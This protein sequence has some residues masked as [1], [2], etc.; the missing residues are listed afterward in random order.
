MLG[1]RQPKLGD[2]RPDRLQ[3]AVVERHAVEIRAD[4]DAD[5]AGRIL[6]ALEL[7]ERGLD[8]RQRQRRKAA[9]AVGIALARRATIES[10]SSRASS[11]RFCASNR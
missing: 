7:G 8:V 11:M 1:D 9:H 2:P 6:D 3:P 4:A 10:F 5:H